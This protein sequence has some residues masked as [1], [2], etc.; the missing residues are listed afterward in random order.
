MNMTSSSKTSSPSRL[1][2]LWGNLPLSQKLLLA[3]GLL[4]S[5]VAIIVF[6][7]LSG[8]NRTK[9]AYE[10]AL[11]KGI[12]VRKLSSQLTINLLQARRDEANFL[13]YWR[14]EGFYTAYANYVTPQK[15]S[16]TEMRRHI[17]E[18]ALFG[19]EAQTVSQGF[20]IN[21]EEYDADIASLNRNVDAY[22]KS[23]DA[24]VAA[25]QKKGFDESTDFESQFREAA[26]NI[27]GRIDGQSG[28]DKLE[29]TF[30]RVRVNEKNY[31][32]Q[33]NQQYADNVHNLIGQLKTQITVSDRLTPEARSDLLTQV[34][35][36]QTAF[37]K[38]VALDQEIAVHNK[39]LTDAASQ[40]QS[41]STKFD[42]LGEQLAADDINTAESSSAQ[43]FTVSIFAGFVVLVISTLLAIVLAR[44]IT[45]PVIRLT[46][47]AQKISE[48]DFEAQAEVVFTDEIGKLAQTFN[49]MTSRLRQAIENIRR[50]TLAVQ[51]TA[52]VSRRLS[53]I[54]DQRQLVAEVVNQI[55]SAFN[56]YHVHIYLVDE[57]N[58]DLIMAGGTG[59]AGR[60]LLER[61][62]KVTKGRGLVGRAAET[63]SRVLVQDTSKDPNWLPNPL[64]PETKSEVAV[65]IS[66]GDEVLGVLDVQENIMDGLQEEDAELLQSIAY[67]VAA[68]LRNART[69]SLTQQQAEQETLINTIGRRIQNTTSV[70]QALQVAVRELGQ[71][72]GAKD[73]R[74]ILSM[75]DSIL[76]ED[77]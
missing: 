53:T 60:I 55:Q 40:V 64:L 34:D 36:Y 33:A 76:H 19:V 4:F 45:Q 28:L 69:Y 66:I 44:Q 26:R 71:A 77:R 72:L 30:L 38:L 17:Q 10:D 43:I 58:E 56:Y 47:T 52:E 35:A 5:L 11:T 21:Q 51:T 54:L 48:G 67:Q 12:E 2:G 68:A 46:N 18:L 70:E 7:T 74:V 8:S 49:L 61:A 23:F 20:D 9:A 6:I 29:S 31:L 73:S 41:L 39:E 13:L 25:Y 42:Q 62:H 16:I 37:D 59:E 3:F 50:R 24:L 27:E 22:E 57:T 63:N 1:S 15:Q 32:A 65:P 75:P 14:D